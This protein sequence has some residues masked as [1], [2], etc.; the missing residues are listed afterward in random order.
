MISECEMIQDPYFDNG[1]V[2]MVDIMYWVKVIACVSILVVL[3]ITVSWRVKIHKKN[4]DNLRIDK[5]SNNL[6]H[7]KQGP[8]PADP[9]KTSDIVDDKHVAGLN[10]QMELERR[11]FAGSKL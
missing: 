8:F 10:G 2:N 11:R 4:N 3:I 7:L 5:H 1:G 9:E 6:T